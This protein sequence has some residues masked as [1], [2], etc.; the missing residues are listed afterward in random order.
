MLSPNIAVKGVVGGSRISYLTSTNKNTTTTNRRVWTKKDANESNV[1]PNLVRSGL[2]CSL[3][4]RKSLDM[5][6][7]VII[8][9]FQ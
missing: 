3:A 9:T 5:A 8:G 2:N 7:G 6:P 1:A 4:D